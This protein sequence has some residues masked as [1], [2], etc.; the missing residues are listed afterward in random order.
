MRCFVVKECSYA[1]KLREFS[2]HVEPLVSHV[3]YVRK[4]F[5]VNKFWV[6]EF[7]LLVQFSTVNVVHSVDLKR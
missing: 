4:T 5:F 7:F 6:S 2:V 3:F 1:R